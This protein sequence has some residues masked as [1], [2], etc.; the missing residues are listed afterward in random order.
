MRANARRADWTTVVAML[1]LDGLK[2]I[3]D[4]E[5]HDAGDRIIVGIAA[6]LRTT[7]REG[8]LLARVGG[9]EFVAVL[10]NAD[11]GSAADLLA[12]LRESAPGP[13][14]HGWTE[15]AEDESLEV[16]LGRADARMYAD[17]SARRAGR[18]QPARPQPRLA[19]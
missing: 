2:R 19:R 15:W 12:R 1:D 13:W 10:P 16:A 5:G 3:N 18:D 4:T 14:S 9:D 17:K 8:D 11:D 6:H 7:L